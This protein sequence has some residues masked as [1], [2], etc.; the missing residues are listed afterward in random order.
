MRSSSLLRVRLQ[1][2]CNEWAHWF[3]NCNKFKFRIKNQWLP[4]K[5]TLSVPEGPVINIWSDKKHYK[6]VIEGR[7]K[8][9]AYL[10]TETRPRGNRLS[11]PGPLSAP[12][13]H[14]QNACWPAD[15]P[16]RDLSKASDAELGGCEVQ[17][18][19]PRLFNPIAHFFDFLVSPIC[20][21]RFLIPLFPLGIWKAFAA[22]A[23]DLGRLLGYLRL[24]QESL[25]PERRPSSCRTP[26]ERPPRRGPE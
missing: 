23:S 19:H 26:A 13:S 21:G 24:V 17:P 14:A 20:S 3:T 2:G 16:G 9:A 18:V 7:Q 8:D 5:G 11:P 6:G 15:R 22:H 4:I 12:P 10:G 1:G 25:H